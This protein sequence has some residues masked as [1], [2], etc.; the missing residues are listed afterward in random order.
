MFGIRDLIRRTGSLFLNR[1]LSG[2]WMPM[3]TAV[4]LG[5]ALALGLGTIDYLGWTAWIARLPGPI[6]MDH[7]TAGNMLDMLTAV[8]VAVLT[9][10]ISITLIVL[11]LAAQSLGARLIE[12]WIAR[13]E[14]RAA[15]AQWVGL[16]AY[17]LVAQV[18]VTPNGPV[19]TAPQG[20]VLGG[21]FLTLIALGWLGYGY[22]LLARTAHVD[23]SIAS[24]GRD[25]AAERQDGPMGPGPDANA[26]A[27]RVVSAWSSG[28]LGGFDRDK[29][30]DAACEAGARIAIAAPEG[31]FLVQ[32]DRLASIWGGNDAVEAMI[33]KTCEIADYRADRPSGPFALALLVE[34]GARALS[35]SLND[36][37]TAATC[38]DWIGHGLSQRLGDEDG[39]LGWHL[40]TVGEARLYVP[41]SGVIAQ[42]LFHLTVFNRA[43][44]GHPYVATRLIDAYA[45][46]L[47]RATAPSDRRTLTRMIDELAAEPPGA[48]R[49]PME[50]DRLRAAVE[51]SRRAPAVTGALAAE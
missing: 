7:G 5:T 12:R 23:T 37:E 35:P 30:I 46:A 45:A 39:A 31:A 51:R 20:V 2:I 41:E 10:Y 16:T 13:V 6:A 15:L 11:T 47:A 38:A 27:E 32:G 9:L 25:Y 43:A 17:S 33:R 34:I 48:T 3:L 28:Y 21:L 44:H 42:S 26:P 19:E 1:I 36:H 40:D 49:S 4:L 14:I 29:L 24:I 8:Q 22:H 18:F 50:A